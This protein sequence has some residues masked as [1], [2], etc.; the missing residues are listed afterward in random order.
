MLAGAPDGHVL[1][2]SGGK[3]LESAPH[4]AAAA[5]D[6]QLAYSLSRSPAAAVSCKHARDC[7]NRRLQP[8]EAVDQVRLWFAQE[9]VGIQAAL[10]Q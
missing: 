5:A 8:R 9:P 4:A 10:A 2:P 7:L 6:C 1:C 3:A